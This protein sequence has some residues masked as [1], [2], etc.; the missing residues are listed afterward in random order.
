MIFVRNKRTYGCVMPTI[1]A[2][3]ARSV[4]KCSIHERSMLG[5]LLDVGIFLEKLFNAIEHSRF[6]TA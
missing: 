4:L 1:G 3:I 2:S 5:G 6:R